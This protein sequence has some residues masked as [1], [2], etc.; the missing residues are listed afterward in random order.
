MGDSV[1]ALVFGGV[2]IL[3][4]GGSAWHQ[5]R[6]RQPP[7]D[8]DDLTRQ[9]AIRKLRRRLQVSAMLVL[10][11]ILIPLGDMLPFF[12]RE[13]VAFVIFWLGVLLLAGW[14]GLLAFAD[15]ASTKAHLS[16]AQRRLAQQKLQLEA[17]LAEYRANRGGS[18]YHSD[19]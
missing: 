4:G 18:R 12:R 11:G 5:W 17:E 19:E 6:Y 3:M 16:R 9:H 15:M 13:P 14:I 10:V 2:L 1:P 8:G 7:D